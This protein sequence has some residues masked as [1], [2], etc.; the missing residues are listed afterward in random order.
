MQ[1]IK[2]AVLLTL[3]FVGSQ[4]AFTQVSA[5]TV[6]ELEAAETKMFVGITKRDPEY[7][8]NDVADDYFSINAME[9]HRILSR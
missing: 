1:T 3:F 8:K 6:K 9:L 5:S 4:N 2:L 7:L